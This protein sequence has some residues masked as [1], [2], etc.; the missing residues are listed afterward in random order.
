MEKLRK[1]LL[2]FR[3]KLRQLNFLT[4]R[5]GTLVMR[6]RRIHAEI[7]KRAHLFISNLRIGLWNFRIK[8]PKLD[9]LAP[10]IGVLIILALGIGL[11]VVG[12]RIQHPN[13]PIT[14]D[15]LLPDFYAN[16]STTLVGIALTVL[17]IDA[18]NRR[19]DD[20]LEKIRLIRDMGCGDNGIAL[21]AVV[22]ITENNLHWKG[23]LRNR[24]FWCA[25]LAGAQLMSADLSYSSFHH[26]D[27]TGADL[28]GAKLQRTCFWHARL[29]GVDFRN[30]DLT[31]GDFIYA[32]L[33]HALVTQEQLQS[34]DRLLGVRLPNGE[35][36]NGRFNRPGDLRDAQTLGVD[37]NDPVAMANLYA[38]PYDQFVRSLDL[39]KDRPEFTDWGNQ[40]IE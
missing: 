2:N 35:I 37:V 12:F 38:M 7:V 4:P 39:R 20:R 22:E 26:A 14:L 28:L 27:F 11:L 13:I 31:D 36:Y 9:L 3:N 23:F 15:A 30:V 21:R 16:V 10:Q 34:A 6:A 8:L 5:M 18:L 25:R 24:H 40:Q 33:T 29:C 19:R 32:D 17:I 1:S